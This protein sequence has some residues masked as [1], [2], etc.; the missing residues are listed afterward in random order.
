[1]SHPQPVAVMAHAQRT[2]EAEQLWRRRF[3][4]HATFGTGII[5]AVETIAGLGGISRFPLSAFRFTVVLRRT[6]QSAIRQFQRLF[7]GFGKPTSTA[8]AGNK[9]VDHDFNVVFMVAAQLQVVVQ[10]NDFAID[11]SA[12]MPTFQQVFEQVFELALLILHNR[13]QDRIP[14]AIRL[15]GNALDD[16]IGG[17]SLDRFARDITVSLT[18]TRKKDAQVVKNFGDRADG[19]ARIAAG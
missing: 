18:D 5:R 7:D 14:G 3:V 4:T 1:M 19:T 6:D 11:T 13:S 12:Q 10:R 8:G 15:T 16:R 17:L 9:S 2:V